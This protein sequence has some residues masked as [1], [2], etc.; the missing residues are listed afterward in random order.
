MR[1]IEAVELAMGRKGKYE[2]MDIQPGDVPATHASTMELEKYIGFKPETS[3]E[4]GVK[5]FIEWYKK[6]YN[7]ELD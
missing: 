1:Y 5:N 2:M 4:K 7:L 3:V 6:H